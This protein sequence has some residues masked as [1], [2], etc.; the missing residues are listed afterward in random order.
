MSKL[1]AVL[2]EL[3]EVNYIDTSTY[4][5]ESKKVVSDR[6]FC[7][8]PLD[9]HIKI[10]FNDS[11]GKEVEKDYI[12]ETSARCP[13]ADAFTCK[14][15]EL[16]LSGKCARAKEKKIMGNRHLVKDDYTK[17]FKKHGGLMSHINDFIDVNNEIPKGQV[18]K[19]RWFQIHD[20]LYKTQEKTRS[21]KV[22]PLPVGRKE[23][24]SNVPH[25]STI[26]RPF[27]N[28]KIIGG[29]NLEVAKQI[30]LISH[31][32]LENASELSQKWESFFTD[33]IERNVIFEAKSDI[34]DRLFN[35][36]AKIQANYD[37]SLIGIG[38]LP[39]ENFGKKIISS[40]DAK[41]SRFIVR[42]Y[43]PMSFRLQTH[44]QVSGIESEL[45]SMGI[46]TDKKFISNF[47]TTHGVMHG[48]EVSEKLDQ[49]YQTVEVILNRLYN[50]AK[51]E[52]LSQS[53]KELDFLLDKNNRAVPWETKNDLRKYFKI[54]TDSVEDELKNRFSDS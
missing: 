13:H 15:P 3:K 7:P 27:A 11:E 38:G 8:Y 50:I 42:G 46:E 20:V 24:Y 35:E 10:K 34:T 18:R 49:R 54:K 4:F 23:D 17:I 41:R 37:V 44:I 32:L 51:E 26:R 2:E 28:G 30:G 14:T 9:H 33:S 31:E 29:E 53:I 22:F 39:Y 19:I 25:T 16:Y 43:V 6:N 40:P 45:K 47:S 5:L 48:I 36:T 21:E 12:F 1:D 52:G